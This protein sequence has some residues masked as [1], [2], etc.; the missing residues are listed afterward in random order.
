MKRGSLNNRPAP[1][2]YVDWRVLFI[3]PEY[4]A[5]WRKYAWR[6]LQWFKGF[7]LMAMMLRPKKHSKAWLEKHAQYQFIV[8][9]VGVWALQMAVDKAAEE[10][11]LWIGGRQ[12]F[13]DWQSY[14]EMARMDGHLVELVVPEPQEL[15]VMFGVP[16]VKYAGWGHQ[17]GR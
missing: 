9:T 8:V 2:V 17:I 11:G 13:D 15:P 6:S 5:W 12:G 14:A 16:T 10:H 3:D 4:G 1:R 7:P